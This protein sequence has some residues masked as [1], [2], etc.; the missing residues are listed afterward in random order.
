MGRS[1]DL[2][3]RAYS[4]PGVGGA[5]GPDA[6]DSACGILHVDMDAFYASVEVR[7]R[8]ELRGRPVIVAGG[9]GRGV[10]LS[11]TYEARPYGVRAAMPATRALRRCPAAVVV[12]PD[13]PSYT[14]A[15]AAVMAIFRT[16]TPLVEPLSLDEAFLDVTGAR[17][18]LRAG[19]AGIGRAIRARVRA[20]L[21]LACSVGVAG[22]KFAAKLASGLAKPDGI[23]VIP[24][25]ELT[26][27]LHPLPV[28]ALWGVGARTADQLDRI[29]LRTVAELAATPP[30]TLRRIVGAAAAEHL[31]ALAA[32]RDP[33]R[34]VPD[35]AEK[36]VG[37]ERTFST[38]LVEPAAL[39]RHLLALSERVAVT[40]RRR[41][42][43]GRVVSI[44][45]RYADF[46]TVTR[47]RTAGAPLDVARDIYRA[48]VDLLDRLAAEHT[49]TERGSL[50]AIRL[51]GVR[52][53]GMTTVAGLPR[54]LSLGEPD[55]GRREAEVAADAARTRFGSAAVGPA[56]LVTSAAT[57]RKARGHSAGPAVERG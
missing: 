34:V 39:R 50:P 16:V 30:A 21:D 53:A 6:D 38:D 45:V 17:R 47:S 1:A 22:T 55:H 10:V 35:A 3:R 18:R 48:A 11:A 56:T 15:S 12:E 51:L 43:A 29:G 14:E 20:E 49:G 32:G 33:R 36:S 28:T 5:A 8:P 37:A 40:L 42:L 31:L 19:A 13:F 9:G 27:V 24:P 44:K 4:E 54:Q 57:G 2:P 23:L 7:R 41:G 25:E 46:T 26:A 52:M